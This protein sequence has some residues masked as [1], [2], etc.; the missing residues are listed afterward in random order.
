MANPL[1]PQMVTGTVGELLAQLRLLQYGVQ[2]APPLKD[3][4]NDLIALRGWTTK[5]VQVKTTAGDTFNLNN[6]PEKYHF[7]LLVKLEG[8]GNNIFLDQTEIFL[9]TKEEI[10]KN[11]YSVRELADKILR[12]DIIDRIFRE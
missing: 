3:T 8:E 11:T 5:C 2:A 9:L 6:L 1:T 7:V 12:Q 10:T 4:G